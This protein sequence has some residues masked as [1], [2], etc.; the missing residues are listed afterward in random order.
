MKFYILAS[1]II[2]CF[3]IHHAINRSN[4]ISQNAEKEF[5]AR[6]KKANE[7]RKKPLDTLH[8]ITIP[9]ERLPMN[10]L[11][12]DET[13]QGCIN[14]LRELS[15]CKI[16][17]LTGY[18]NT[19]LKLEYGTANITVL[20]QYDQSYTLLAT[21]LQKWADTLWDAGL[22]DEAVSIMEFALETETDISRTYYLLAEHY[23]KTGETDK[24]SRLSEYAEN[25]RS[26]NRQ[27]ILRHLAELSEA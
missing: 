27:Q 25:L 6:E 18:T 14:T 3:V 26:G 12:Q 11:T 8:Y 1:V 15:E 24:L 10:V 17:N 20:S 16:V 23:R 7:T 4:R 2:F 22:E 19:D 13:V 9:F 5:W 21:T